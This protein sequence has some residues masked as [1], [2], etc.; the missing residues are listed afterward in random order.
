MEEAD[1]LFNRGLSQYQNSQV[2]EAIQFWRQAL[3]IYESLGS[4]HQILR[5]KVR[6]LINLG[7]AAATLARNS[8]AIEY[9]QQS[10]AISREIRDSQGEGWS[11]R[12]LGYVYIRLGEYRQALAYNQQALEL[13]Q[14]VNDHHGQI[15]A[16]ANLG[17]ASYFQ[18]NYSQAIEYQKQRSELAQRFGL[19][20]EEGRARNDLGIIEYALG[21]YDRALNYYQ[22]AKKV[23]SETNDK[24]LIEESLSNLGSVFLDRAKSLAMG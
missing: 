21:Q 9:A 8:E 18:G 23:G 19:P 4:D 14:Q 6:T 11:V 17:V 10:L 3:E 2:E 12:I 1:Q 13:T 24:I 22:Q 15:L 5:R 7:N 20:R 16:L